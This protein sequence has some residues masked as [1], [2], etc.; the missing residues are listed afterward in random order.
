MPAAPSEHAANRD[1]EREATSRELE[2]LDENMTM[3]H[4][5]AEILCQA[6]AHALLGELTAEATLVAS[7][8]AQRRQAAAAT[9][10][11]DGAGSGAEGGTRKRASPGV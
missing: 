9:G 10:D 2:R 1:D 4:I 6:T 3:W 5:G 7:D 8:E 11:A